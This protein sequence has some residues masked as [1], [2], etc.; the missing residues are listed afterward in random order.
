MERDAN[1]PWCGATSR[2]PAKLDANAGLTVERYEIGD[3][4]I[5]RERVF[6][7]SARL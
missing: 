4:T 6:R 1:P 2:H 5:S 3:R 7:R